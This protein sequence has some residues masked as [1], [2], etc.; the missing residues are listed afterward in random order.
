MLTTPAIFERYEQLRERIPSAATVNRT[1]DIN[2]LSD[3]A[4]Q[5]SAFVFDA[6]GVLNV[7]SRPIKG[8]EERLCELRSRGC[9]IR[10]LTNAASYDHNGA[11]NKFR[12]LGLSVH[13][14]EII[15]SRQAAVTT[16]D[17]RQWGALG[18]PDDTFNDI[19]VPV[20]RV[21]NTADAF[22]A[23]EGFL[24][25]SAT[26]WTDDRQSLLT[27]SLVKKP[28]PVVVANP[29]LVA[30]RDDGFS[31]EPG[32]FGHLLMDA[33]IDTVRFYGKPF[34]DVYDLIEASLPDVVPENI[35]MCGDTLHTDI[36]GA[37][38]RGWE[39]VLVTQDGLFSGYS[40]E[41]FCRASG[42]HPDWRLPRI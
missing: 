33:G 17:H 40:T 21:G 1:Q 8:A 13:A 38:A 31:L 35:A 26:G 37:A 6:F 15:T 27:E 19:A 30:P 34:P 2:S 22:D 3:I 16:L 4:G 24:F 9:Q 5:V 20:T 42:L 41:D 32:H 11:V 36:I 18:A 10:V 23:V 12:Q 29:D 14:N 25:L 28:R 39:T 7:G